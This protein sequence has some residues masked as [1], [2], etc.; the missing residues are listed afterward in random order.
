M[1]L[2]WPIAALLVSLL[3]AAPAWACGTGGA[4]SF[5]LESL[6]Q[7]GGNYALSIERE[8][9]RLQL[10]SPAGDGE[11][12]LK[13]QPQDSLVLAEK[14]PTDESHWKRVSGLIALQRFPLAEGVVRL[15]AGEPLFARLVF[16]ALSPGEVFEAVLARRFAV[17]DRKMVRDWKPGSKDYVSSVALELAIAGP[18]GRPCFL[19]AILETYRIGDS[20]RRV[21]LFQVVDARPLAQ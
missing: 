7:P 15:T 8:L 4:V 9:L 16:S 17:Y 20:Y 11:L 10:R 1:E 3:L 14:G 5:F 21:A 2:R 13:L 19:G 18:A 6:W 12:S